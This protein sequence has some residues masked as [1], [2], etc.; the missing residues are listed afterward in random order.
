MTKTVPADRPSLVQVEAPPDPNAILLGTGKGADGPD[1]ESWFSMFGQVTAR[2]VS[3]A[4]LTP[5]LPDPAKATGA[6]VVLAPGGGFVML[7]MENEGWPVAQ[8][9]AERGIAVFVLKY[10]LQTS[11]VELEAFGRELLAK[12]ADINA[13][14]GK[15]FELFTPAEA[16]EDAEAALRIVRGRAGEWGVDPNRVGMLGFSAGAMTALG[17]VQRA[18]DQETMPSFIAPIY[19]P[20]VEV[21]VPDTAPPMFVAMALDD[22]LFGS[23]GFGLIDSWRRAG[24]ASELHV[25]QNGGHGFGMGRP[26]TTCGDWIEAFYRWVQMNGYLEPS[27]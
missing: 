22:E 14:P 26:G 11:P 1:I 20:M 9:L 7:A 25:Y 18:A 5:V 27:K 2:N 17:L 12:L 24:K 19:G 15:P 4:T 6:A 3:R 21:E 13:N 10:R 16:V 23:S 8:W